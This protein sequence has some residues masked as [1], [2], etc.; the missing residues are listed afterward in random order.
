[1]I[2]GVLARWKKTLENVKRVGEELREGERC[3]AREG[4]SLTVLFPS[5]L[6]SVS[7]D[8]ASSTPLW[9]T[10]LPNCMFQRISDLCEC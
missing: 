1:M 8:S 5:F 2:Y 9:L 3:D 4:R 10:K 6:I 7:G